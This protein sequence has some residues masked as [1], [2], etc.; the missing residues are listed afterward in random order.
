MFLDFSLIQ[1]AVLTLCVLITGISKSGFAGGLGVMT[2][3]LLTLVMSPTIAVSLM[4]PVLLVMDMM[5][6]RVWFGK[7][8][9]RSLLFLVPAGILG[10]IVGYQTFAAVN[11]D[12]IRMMLGILCIAFSVNGLSG[13]VKVKSCSNIWGALLGGL[14]GFTSFVAHAGGP[15]VNVY[16]LSKG[17]SK[18]TY[19][20]TAVVFFAAINLA[21]VPPYIALGQFTQQNI[22]TALLLVPLSLLGIRLGVVAQH[23]LDERKFFFIIYSLLLLLGF[24]L[25]LK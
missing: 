13:I 18:Q 1:L 7:Q 15:P 8:H 12:H 23:H 21:K 9:N 24:Y 14:S 11:E 3:P 19:L 16:L 25:L 2:V 10:V 20:S 17:L 22:I 4:L 5:S 6:L